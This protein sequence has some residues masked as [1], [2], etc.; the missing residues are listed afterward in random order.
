M[1]RIRARTLRQ[2]TTN[3]ERILWSCLRET[4]LAGL[5]FRRQAPIGK[6][7]A[8]FACHQAKIVVELDGSQHGED[9]R[10]QYDA[11][12]TAFLQSRGYQVLRFGNHEVV[13]DL[14]RVVDSIVTAA[15]IPR[16]QRK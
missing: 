5:H 9:K 13:R 14:H 1:N 11:A 4:K 3:A 6:Y 8:D 16:D 12:R 2:N 7:I 15:Q 10:A